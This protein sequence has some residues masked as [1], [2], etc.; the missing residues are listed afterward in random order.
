MAVNEA[1]PA[2]L[3][4]TVVSGQLLLEQGA[5]PD[6]TLSAAGACT[7]R[8]Y[9][10]SQ[11]LAET[12]CTED[13]RFALALDTAA[14]PS[15][16]RATL[17]LESPGRLRGVL[18]VSVGQG[19]DLDIGRVA[20]G[21][22][23]TV[24]GEVIDG[25]GKPVPNVRVEARPN[26]DLGE[27]LPWVRS[28]DAQGR[29]AFDSLPVGPVTLRVADPRFSAS[30]VEAVSPEDR[31]VIVVRPLEDL[32]G[33]VVASR[34]VLD[35]A[36][37]R[38]E[39]SSVWPPLELPLRA[40]K[41]GSFVFEELPDG[42][43]AIEVQGKGKAS[44]PLENVTPDMRVDLALID[45]F[46][47]PVRV[48][49]G[50]G[51]PVPDGRVIVSYGSVAMLQKVATTGADGLARLGPVVPGPYVVRADA[52]GYLPSIP[53]EI[54]VEG[55]MDEP[56]VL[57]LQRAATIAGV[58]VN[59]GGQ[60][61]GGA[62]VE[63]TTQV[64]F[65]AG[66]AD[67]RASLFARAAAPQ[68]G[69]GS[70]G[71]TTGPVPDIPGLDEPDDVGDRG[72]LTDDDGSFEIEGLFPGTYS[73]VAYHGG[74]ASSTP[75]AVELHSGE[76]R[77]GL[78]LTLREGQRLTGRVRDSRDFPVE[79]ARVSVDRSSFV[80]TDRQGLFDAGHFRGTVEVT[81]RASGLAPLR[82]SVTMRNRPRDV[83]LVLLDADS[84]IDGRV[85]D[86]KDRPIERV[87]VQL[88]LDDRLSP[89]RFGE[90]DRQ[91]VFAFENLPAG[92]GVLSFEHPE[93][94]AREFGVRIRGKTGPLEFVLDDA[95]G[96]KAVAVDADTGDGIGNARVKTGIQTARVGRD[97]S[98]ML[99]GLPQTATL[100]VSA[101]GYATRRLTV[102]RGEV[103]GEL[104]VE[105][106]PGGSVAGTVVDD[107]GD[108]VGGVLVEV[109]ARRGRALLGE[110]RTSRTGAFRVDDIAA[111]DVVVI[112]RTPPS[113]A[114]IVVD[115]EVQT[116]VLEG[117]VTRD[118]D[119][120]FDR[121]QGR[122]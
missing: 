59:E 5:P 118:V 12:R 112:A 29:F 91:G 44:V 115:T 120:R 36:M 93:Y 7:A 47:V 41:D 52:S 94:S 108:P 10:G 119:L 99:R 56:I 34:E 61:V 57:E 90:T 103:E 70:L 106:V 33:R 110:D 97:G 81:V 114:D 68:A 13:G 48:V 78:V 23:Y 24:S 65:T 30:V 101:P 85:R 113:L 40:S 45:A 88:E 107:L 62:V 11:R 77:D 14:T 71:V 86:V 116:D 82:T 69:S 38:I 100:T 19:S 80:F 104:V 16:A 64:E 3:P 98:V 74:H 109:R 83:E 66:E 15:S 50:D 28:C 43:Y 121:R 31:V 35:E 27:P 96:I 2:A 25:H 73:L 117:L 9:S 122:P 76:S 6:D 102:S 95:W 92:G 63:V 58:V 8:L 105:L 39:G 72:L 32:Q 49:D 17:E 20:L 1:S 87:V 46:E 4:A 18:E 21:E 89:M 51:D 111:G 75:L 22:G 37:V 60:P 53:A 55:E 67:T 26:P 84:S 42:V 54:L 79:G